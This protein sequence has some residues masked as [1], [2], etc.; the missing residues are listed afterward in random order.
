MSEPTIL[1]VITRSDWG[2]APHVV[3]LLAE[4]TA[5]DVSVA[6]APGGALIDRLK[7]T[8]VTVYEQPHFKRSIEPMN[9]L[10]ELVSLYQLMRR[11]S[12][13]L[14]HCHSTKA[15]LLGRIAASL[16]GIP[17]VFTV[18][19][20]G[21]YNTEFGSFRKAI[22][23]GERLLSRWTDAIVCVSNDDRRQGITRS[24][25]SHTE[26][27]VVHNG[28]APIEIPEDREQLDSHIDSISDSTVIGAIARLAPQKN[29]LAILR[30]GKQIQD[31]GE[32][33]V[34]VLIG[35]GPLME[36]CQEY[37]DTHDVDAHLLG[38]QEHALE[39]L[40]DID[41]FL[42][43][44]RFEGLPL[45]VIECLHLGIPIVAY[46][47]GG[48][49]EAIE[50]GETGYIV[51]EDDFEQ[52]VERVRTLAHEPDR[53]EQ[54]GEQA[55]QTAAERFTAERMVTEYER[56]YADILGYSTL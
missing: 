42:L 32:D 54:M 56:V 40:C 8:D 2:G 4:G 1:H 29:P 37:V 48:V 3:Q 30:A 35:D 12:F 9:D 31:E 39:L 22:V 38:F 18:H 5:A 6:C 47:V 34:V 14:V 41:T 23:G 53:R 25:L 43:P 55:Q 33:V 19:G 36:E 51:P 24:I 50:D 26:D 10:R 46:D 44:S 16:A 7:E 15:G 21:F 20:W 27:V 13:D 11:E 45:T 52:F 17:S 49:A 28:I